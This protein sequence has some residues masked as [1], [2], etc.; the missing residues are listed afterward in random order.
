VRLF[1]WPGPVLHAKTVVVDGIWSAVGSYNMD[2]R[3]WL[4]DLEVNIHV[5]DRAFGQQMEESF[6]QDLASSKEIHLERW[7]RRPWQDKVLE[8]MASIF[9]YWL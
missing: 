6:E 5:L 2:N 1:E 9:R 3:S 8:H 4:H 7:I